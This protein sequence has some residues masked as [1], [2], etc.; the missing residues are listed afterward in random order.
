MKIA[1]ISMIRDGW[2]G[3]EE[4]WA[5]MARYALSKGDQVA[6]SYIAVVNQSDRKDELRR[7]GLRE[8]PRNT[9]VQPGL[10]IP[11]RWWKKIKLFILSVFNNPYTTLFEWKPDVVIYNGTCYSVAEEHFLFRPLQR[12]G[13]AFIYIGHYCEEQLIPMSYVAKQRIKRFYQ[14]ASIIFITSKRNILVA[15]KQLGVDLSSAK[16]FRNPINMP[17]SDILPFPKD[18][19]AQFAMVGNLRV[20][21]KGQDLALRALSSPA[22]LKREW[23]LNIYGAGSDE[24]MLR[25]M[26]FELGIDKRVVFH[27]VS[28]NIRDIWSSN[29]I[30]LMPSRMEG[31]PL[32]VVEAMLC[33]RPTVLTDVGG[34]REW[35][36][37]G[38]EGWVVKELTVASYREALEA[39]WEA[40]GS[41]ELIGVNAHKKAISLYDPE[42]GQTFYLALKE[43]IK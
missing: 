9:L 33:G 21:H 16:S 7:M 28:Q 5:S 25:A 43:A 39:A 2:G 35:V 32:A 22:W 18:E 27:G 14:R 20:L 11:L 12:S 36:S 24:Q 29:Q 15:S 37:C 42:P 41:W 23:R 40:R 34:H 19:V 30:L 17:S 26:T 31:M 6:H 13:A 4:W 3:S 38:T 1:V 8:F 10:P